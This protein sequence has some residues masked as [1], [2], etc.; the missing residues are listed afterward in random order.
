[1][2]TK[3]VLVVDDE[4]LVRWSIRQKLEA[5]GYDTLEASSAAEALA[6]F[7]EHMPDMVTLD[8]RMPDDSGL[9]VLLEMKRIADDIPVVMITAYG[10]VDDAVKALKM[11]AYDYLEKPI[12]F[13]R[14]L[15][16]IH[17]ALETTVLRTEVEKSKR[18]QKRAYSVDRIVGESDSMGKVKNLIRRVADSEATTILVQGESGTGKDLAAKA[19]HYES[20]RHRR[21]FM[22]LNCAAIPEQLLENELFGHEKGAFTDAG[23]LK[24][25]LMELADGGTVFFDEVSEMPVNLQAKLLRVLEDHTFRRIGG[26]KDIH[27]D[28][29]V[30]CASNRDLKRLTREGKFREDLYY[31]LS[32]IPIDIPPL[33]ERKEDLDLL[34]GYFIDHYNRTFTKQVKGLTSRS[35]QLLVQYDWPGNVRELKN[36]IERAL[37]LQDEDLIDVDV[38]PLY[39]MSSRTADGE[40]GDNCDL[41]IP[42][43]G[44]DLYQ[45]EKELIR[46]ALLKSHGN[47][48][49]ASR[50]LSITRD[51]LRYKM[52]KYGISKPAQT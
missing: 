3:T 45:V 25:G 44:I 29:R 15:H 36:A 27:V 16:S 11:G 52:K 48:S 18:E 38:F 1:M 35:R 47:Q 6:K 28:L 24:K 21:P 42:M 5:A 39:P 40:L 46:K 50:L 10:A 8:I 2:S 9:K 7:Q 43:R 22:I 34:A 33:R 14:L 51:T 19:L 41:D 23:T 37:I 13:D 49:Q 30:V 12:N 4:K 26:V 20:S 32:V 31:R 17:N